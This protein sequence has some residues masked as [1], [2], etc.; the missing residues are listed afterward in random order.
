MEKAHIDWS[1]IYSAPNSDAALTALDSEIERVGYVCLTDCF[2]NINR[3]G[4]GVLQRLDPASA[5]IDGALTPLDDA[6]ERRYKI[7]VMR[8]EW[9][10][11]PQPGDKVIHKIAKPFKDA[12]G[13]R[14]PS[15]NPYLRDGT[16]ERKFMNV[17]EYT[18]DER[19]CIECDYRSAAFFISQYG[20]HYDPK[21]GAVCRR[22]ELSG[23]TC[24][25][26]GPD[27]APIP[28]LDGNGNQMVDANGN[29][30][31]VEKYVWYWRYKEV[32]PWDYENLPLRGG[33][34]AD[35][36]QVRSGKTGRRG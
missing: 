20:V 26:M 11:V 24:R 4:A 15:K 6:A 29:P 36:E 34:D 1:R 14:L 10:N 27:G 5:Y 30:R 3:G 31:F 25:V 12:R 16:Y 28:L 32:P 33:G 18:V 19:G 13:R 8:D 9:G 23:G 22:K 2:A 21:G 7:L 17:R 35:G